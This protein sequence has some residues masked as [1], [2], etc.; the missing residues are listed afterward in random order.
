[1]KERK[2]KSAIHYRRMTEDD[3][4]DAYKLS[5]SALWPHQLEDWQFIQ[6]LGEGIVA[7]KASGIIGTAMCWLHG[8][9]H[10]SIGM[11]LVA[12][13]HRRNGIGRELLS[14]LLKETGDR[15][16]VAHATPGGLALF[17]QCGF[18][19]TGRVHQHQGSVRRPPL[20]PLGAG[21]RIR[22]A[23][24]RDE[25]ALGE[26]FRR[27]C[28]MP[29]ATVFRQLMQAA[30]I[31]VID[32]YGELTGFAALRKFGHGYVIGPVIAP[33]AGRA[34]ALIAHWAGA[35]VGAF[36][37]VDTPAGSGLGPW[38]TEIGLVQTEQAVHVMTLGEPPRSAPWT[39]R[40]ALLSQSLG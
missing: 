19:E 35:H 4:P 26:L 20:A 21:E 16:T 15:T 10:A 11:L 38:L 1:M 23:N 40:F 17:E 18:T 27:A 28:G 12:P 14:R 30:N 9:D 39:G 32:F 13:D 33:D 37:R 6:Q 29:R 34:S 8:A 5:L 7:E 25:P 24:A 22:P 36:M 2:A 31:V 3:V